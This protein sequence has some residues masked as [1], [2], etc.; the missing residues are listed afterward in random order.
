MRGCVIDDTSPIT[1]ENG[2]LLYKGTPV[3]D[4]VALPLR[5]AAKIIGISETTLYKEIG[6]KRLRTTSLKLIPRTELDR[7]LTA[8]L[9]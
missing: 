8:D 7:Y 1:T 3:R 9:L 5:V 4:M 2:V 6:L